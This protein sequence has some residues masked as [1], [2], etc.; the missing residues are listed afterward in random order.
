MPDLPSLQG[1]TV[2][3]DPYRC[4]HDRR[5]STDPG[6]RP[7][8]CRAETG[9][10]PAR[11]LTELRADHQ[12]ER[13]GRTNTLIMATRWADCF[14]EESINP[15]QL[16]IPGGDR[17]IHPG[18]DGTPTMARFPIR[19][20]AVELGK[21]G[22]AAQ[23][24]I[25]DALDLRHRHPR[26]WARMCRY[27][28]DGLD[29]Q[30]IARATHHLTLAQALQVDASV[31]RYV[32]RWSF[33]KLMQHVEAK[34]IEVD[35]DNL[36]R[37]AEQEAARV[38]V[39]LNQSNQHGIKGIYARTAA[40]VAIRFYATVERLADILHRQGHPGTR[41]ELLAEAIDRMTNPLDAVRMIAQ[42]TAPSLFDPDVD[43][44]DESLLFPAGHR[45]SRD[46][47]STSTAAPG[48]GDTDSP[49]SSDDATD[50]G[51][52]HRCPAG[53]GCEAE[54][55]TPAAEQPD[56]D[57]AGL[58]RSDDDHR[59][60]DQ[61]TD[62]EAP[63]DP[64]DEQ[65]AAAFGRFPRC[66]D[67][68]R[69]V[70]QTLNAISHLDPARFRPDATL[71]VHIARETLADSNGVTRVEDIGPVLAGVVADWLR[72]CNVTVEPVIDLAVELTPAD[73]YEIPLAMRERIFLKHPGSRFPYSG[74]TGRHL[75]LDHNNP[76][77]PGVRGQTREDNLAPFCR[78]EHNPITHGGWGRRQP[79]PGT[80]VFRAPHGSIT[81]V[82]ATG[83]HDLG[84]GPYA[85]QI[86]RAAVPAKRPG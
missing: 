60:V 1:E 70:R 64:G 29:C 39:W 50:A 4:F 53:E 43:P 19:E 16:A 62:G 31:A 35:A 57:H 28:I 45:P 69:L 34:I 41:N 37:L 38:G 59:G 23:R 85:Q 20:F 3:A 68:P 67:N 30:L 65:D 81:L 52:A 42:D 47:S 17:P 25:G 26:L 36:Q 51:S 46:H 77:R 54:H 10:D 33:G 78:G 80:I 40:P 48:C 27:E 21:S 55:Q 13:I 6:S 72:G 7:T 49:T 18:G 32:G 56:T 86:W 61:Q 66:D 12:L 74:A 24:I 71:Y 11:V 73:S 8:G 82:N 63:P 44:D 5:H 22:G 83:S 76:Y 9:F 58:E 84:R 75:D 15:Y 79:E 14:P 2:I